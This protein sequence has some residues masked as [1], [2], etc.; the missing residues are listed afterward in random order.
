MA[1]DKNFEDYAREDLSLNSFDR[2]YSL[3]LYHYALFKYHRRLA[4]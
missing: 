1:G 3:I 4:A 2:I